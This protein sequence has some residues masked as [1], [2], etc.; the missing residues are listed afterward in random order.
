[1]DRRPIRRKEKEKPFHETKPPLPI[2]QLWVVEAAGT[3]VRSRIR[4]F[5]FVQFRNRPLEGIERAYG[6]GSKGG[7]Q[8]P[9]Q[10]VSHRVR[11]PALSGDRY[12]RESRW[13]CQPYVRGCR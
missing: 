13:L 11:I 5:V 4:F 8:G 12:P 3:L 7:A 10:R 2:L 6:C 9:F 1:M